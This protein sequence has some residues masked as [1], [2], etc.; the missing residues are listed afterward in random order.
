MQPR[1]RWS[2]YCWRSDNDTF[3]LV[4]QTLFLFHDKW[5]FDHSSSRVAFFTVVN[6][7]KFLGMHI[8][9]SSSHLKYEHLYYWN[10]FWKSVEIRNIFRKISECYFRDPVYLH[11]RLQKRTTQTQT[12]D[13]AAL[14]IQ[15][16]DQMS[17]LVRPVPLARCAYYAIDVFIA[18]ISN[19]VR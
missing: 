4:R 9:P 16:K 14:V 8:W 19:E 6:I 11:L 1:E 12:T 17:T 10:K 7:I 3:K 5:N 15:T 18:C 2:T 13:A